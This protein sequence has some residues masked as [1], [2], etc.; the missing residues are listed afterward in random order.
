MLP[1]AAAAEDAHRNQGGTMMVEPLMPAGKADPFPQDA[2]EAEAS[3]PT[4]ER[5]T[6][7]PR[8]RS[9]WQEWLRALATNADAALAAAQV[10]REL[11]SPGRDAW[12]DA[13]AEDAPLLA[14]PAVA[15]YAPLLAVE[16]D[17]QRCEES[18]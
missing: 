4:V 7:E 9:A 1:L 11:D 18:R 2:S 12:L 8:L 10:Y 6:L 13:L 15:I 14:V 17:P 3:R 16:Q 5:G